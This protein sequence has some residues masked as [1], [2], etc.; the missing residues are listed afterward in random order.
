MYVC[1]YYRVRRLWLYFGLSLP[2]DS[3][4]MARLIEITVG[5]L[6]S[7]PETR[8]QEILGLQCVR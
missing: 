4:K 1:M 8:L 5:R 6:T 3:D 2:V 7:M